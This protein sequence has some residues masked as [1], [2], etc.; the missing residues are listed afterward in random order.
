MTVSSSLPS[1]GLSTCRAGRDWGWA[2]RLCAKMGAL[3]AVFELAD[4]FSYVVTVAP[5]F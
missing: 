3:Q 4:G 2:T 1:G 5:F